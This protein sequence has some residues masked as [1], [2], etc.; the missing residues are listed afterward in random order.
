MR[1]DTTLGVQYDR[2]VEYMELQSEKHLQEAAVHYAW[3]GFL[4]SLS[5][6]GTYNLSYQADQIP[7]LYDRSYP[8]SFIGLKLSL[9]LFEGGKRY[10]EIS[11]AK[12]QL[13]RAEYDL[14][15]SKQAID[16]EFA[17]ASANYKSSLRTYYAL[18]ENADLAEEVYTTLQLQYKSGIKTY[19]DVLTAENDLRSAEANR[20][21]ALFQVISS[22]IDVEKALGLIRTGLP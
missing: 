18:K 6:F 4:P 21:N 8:N 11:L 17:Q 5:A 2:R 19:L 15:R 10:Q 13:E 12:L 14:V 9:P 22:K 1:V 20:T 7:P 3:W 16:D